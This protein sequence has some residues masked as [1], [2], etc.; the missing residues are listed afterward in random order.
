M[1]AG[2][3]GL[4]RRRV[5]LPWPIM[6]RRKKKHSRGEAGEFGRLA[7]ERFRDQFQ[8]EEN[9]NGTR[10][11][12]IPEKNLL[13]RFTLFSRHLLAE[14]FWLKILKIDNKGQRELL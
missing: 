10:H 12:S 8:Q 2:T 7:V 9:Y 13:Y 14:S 4:Q 5:L 3:G 1:D 6:A 11:V